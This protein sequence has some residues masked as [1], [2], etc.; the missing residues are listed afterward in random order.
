MLS[1]CV[2]SYVVLS[3]IKALSFSKSKLPELVSAANRTLL[4][5]LQHWWNFNSYC[6]STYMLCS[7]KCFSFYLAVPGLFF[8]IF[9]ISWRLITLQ[10]CSEF[11]HTLKWISHEFTCI[12][13]PDPPSHLPLHPVPLGLPSAPGPSACLMHPTLA[14]DLF[15][16]GLNCGMWGP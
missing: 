16:P 14:G 7:A 12:P 2:M 3:Y 1:L 8:L 9:F 10:Y 6:F 13:H 4:W 5:Y 11:C 15:V